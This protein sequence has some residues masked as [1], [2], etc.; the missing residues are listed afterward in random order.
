MSDCGTQIKQS[1]IPE[2]VSCLAEASEELHKAIEVLEIRLSDV[3][4][5]PPPSTPSMDEKPSS[6]VNLV[7]LAARLRERVASIK[8]ATTHITDILSRLEV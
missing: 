3:L 7:N 6:L 2:Q 8:V 1:Q 4:H 5:S